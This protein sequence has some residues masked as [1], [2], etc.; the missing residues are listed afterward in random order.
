MPVVDEILKD[1]LRYF[2][3]SYYKSLKDDAL[4]TIAWHQ[5]QK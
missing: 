3:T 5:I 2:T 1:R 4:C